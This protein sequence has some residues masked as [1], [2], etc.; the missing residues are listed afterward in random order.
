MSKL[1]R[2]FSKNSS[3]IGPAVIA[4]VDAELSDAGMVC[5]IE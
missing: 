5:V 4:Y 1:C 3:V 2:T